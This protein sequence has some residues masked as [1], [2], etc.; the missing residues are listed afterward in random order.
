MASPLAVLT[1][2][3]SQYLLHRPP[4]C[5]F[6]DQLVQKPDLLSEWI[7][8]LLHPIAAD[9]TSDEMGIGVEC[10]LR[11][12]LL[13]RRLA[14]YLLLQRPFI[15]PCEPLNDFMQLLLRAPFLL[16]LGQI[17]WVDRRERHPSNSLIVVTCVFHQWAL[18]RAKRR[19][20]FK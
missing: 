4:F 14:L 3:S 8:N 20:L 12:E 19:T 13:E 16:D 15:E 6:I 18:L 17:V 9:H 1:L 11:K 10:G 7:L 5:Q 2:P